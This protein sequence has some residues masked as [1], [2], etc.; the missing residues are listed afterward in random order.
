MSSSLSVQIIESGEGSTLDNL[1]LFI[2]KK[3]VLLRL[4]LA[5]G[6]GEAEERGSSFRG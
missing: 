2:D 3:D 1:F 5:A 6:G 4:R